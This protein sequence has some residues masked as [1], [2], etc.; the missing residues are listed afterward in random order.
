MGE[1]TRVK[2][3]REEPVTLLAFEP[4]EKVWNQLPAL[5]LQIC[6][7]AWRALEKLTLLTDARV[8]HT[9]RDDLP[10]PTLGRQRRVAVLAIHRELGVHLTESCVSAG[11]YTKIPAVRT[12]L[13]SCLHRGRGHIQVKG[14]RLCGV[15]LRYGEPWRAQC[16]WS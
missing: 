15:L 10:P 12:G 3:I 11:W 5:L 14:L 1:L 6:P 4:F 16:V 8:S 13:E 7:S 9:P 2:R